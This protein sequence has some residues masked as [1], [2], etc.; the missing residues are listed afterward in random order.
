[1]RIDNHIYRDRALWEAKGWHIPDFDRE[2]VMKR[3]GKIPFGCILAA[4][5]FSGP[6]SAGP[7]PGLLEQGK[8]DRGLIVAESFDWTLIDEIY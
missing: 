1:M 2:A 3:T 5:I 8:L 7:C 4:A 6:L